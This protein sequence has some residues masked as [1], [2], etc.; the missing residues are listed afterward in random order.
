M[1]D[2]VNYWHGHNVK[3]SSTVKYTISTFQ[4][5]LNV[6]SHNYLSFYS[7]SFWLLTL[8][9]QSN[10]AYK[11]NMA[12]SQISLEQNEGKTKTLIV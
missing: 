4:E 12:N 6:N 10:Y 2:P 7:Y 11:K 3:I 1:N 8:T 9:G 5:V